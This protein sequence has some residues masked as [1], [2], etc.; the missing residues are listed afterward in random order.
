MSEL[1]SDFRPSTFETQPTFQVGM[2]L[3]DVLCSD[4]PNILSGRTTPA[5]LNFKVPSRKENIET[6]KKANV[7]E[8]SSLKKKQTEK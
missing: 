8:N 7:T 3:M 2:S 6:S 1:G 4:S 5:Y